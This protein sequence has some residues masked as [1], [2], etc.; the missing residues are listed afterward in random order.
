MKKILSNKKFNKLLN[1]GILP[2]HKD[3]KK[4]FNFTPN[5]ASTAVLRIGQS[6]T[7]Q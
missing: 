7:G 4:T 5:E 6:F 2:E 3:L 1:E